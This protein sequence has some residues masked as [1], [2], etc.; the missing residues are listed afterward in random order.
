[1]KKQ[2]VVSRFAHKI[3][4]LH[5][6]SEDELEEA[7]WEEFAT[8]F[9]QVKP[10]CDNKFASLEGVSFGDVITEEY[11]HFR[12]RYIKGVTKEM[13]LLF[14]DRKFEIKRVIDD[15]EKGRMLS[16]IALEV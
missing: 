7:I 15:Q 16:I 13:R 12:T 1:M 3:S 10:V 11:F 14:H 8:C 6:R 5:D 2:S 9:A 4:I